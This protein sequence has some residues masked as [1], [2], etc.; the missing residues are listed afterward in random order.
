[1]AVSRQTTEGLTDELVALYAAVEVRLL[2]LIARHLE[3][4]TDAPEWVQAK[5]AEL[6]TFRRRAAR[7]VAAATSEAQ[8]AA[9]QAVQRG[10]LLGAAA[11]E[12]SLLAAGIELTDPPEHAERAVTALARALVGQLEAVGLQV[13]RQ[14]ADAYRQAVARAAA[15][16]LTGAATRLQAAQ[17][18]L[19]D[20]ARRG[21]TGFTDRA[22]RRWSLA[23][24]V[25]MAT[26]TTTAQAA[27]T[28]AMDRIEQGGISLFL[29]SDSPRECEA[30]R[31][32]EGRV[33]SRG[34]VD[35]LQRNAVTGKLERVRVDGTV[36]QATSA[37]LFH[38]GCTHNLSAYVHGATRR[39]QATASPR[40]YAEKQ[41]QRRLE[42]HIRA[43][44]RREAVA[45]TPEARKAARAKVRAYQAQLRDHVA[46][47]GLPRKR[48]RE[49]VTAA[50]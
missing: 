19:D 45:V 38:P 15:G 48:E 27:I 30:C 33:L 34:P 16:T 25:E 24:Y 26:R 49:S 20:L 42:R 1:M 7:M 37:G 40:G 39:G 8:A 43:W 3:A 41:E 17:A 10:Y 29:V 14:A 2:W 21:L 11:G 4:G 32:W 46:A 22:G 44:K 5:M 23:S 28:G 12:A 31:P 18:A 36:A 50:R 6:Q 9:G 35:A 13:T 47:T